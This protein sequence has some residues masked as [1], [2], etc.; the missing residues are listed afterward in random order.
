M[1]PLLQHNRV[2]PKNN[3]TVP[4]LNSRGVSAYWCSIFYKR[5]NCIRLNIPTNRFCTNEVP[6]TTT[7]VVATTKQN[8]PIIHRS[9]IN[10]AVIFFPFFRCPSTRAER[11]EKAEWKAVTTVENLLFVIRLLRVLPRDSIWN[12]SELAIY[13]SVEAASEL[14]KVGGGVSP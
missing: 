1:T 5:I 4:L 8:A 3:R 10:W 6:T 11:R 9:Y 7:R 2:Y 12:P 14:Q 13:Y